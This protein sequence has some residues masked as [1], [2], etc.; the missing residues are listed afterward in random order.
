MRVYDLALSTPWAITEEMRDV[1]MK[2]AAREDLNPEAVAKELGRP[3]ENTR[4]VTVRDGVAIIPVSGPMFRYANLFMQIS[5][6]VSVDIL[7]T[8]IGAAL[9]DPTIHSIIL[10]IDSPGGT[11]KGIAELSDMVYAARPEKTIIAYV[12]GDGASGAYWFASA[13]S[14]VVVDSIAVL[15]SIGVVLGASASPDSPGR[16]E[17][18]SSQSP[19][20][21]INP[22]SPDGKAKIQGMIDSLAD[23]FVSRVA[24]NRNVTT[25]K[26]LSDFGQGWVFVGEEAVTAGLADRVG[27]LEGLVAELVM[28]HRA[29]TGA[30]AAR[31]NN[32]TSAPESTMENSTAAGAVAQTPAVNKEYLIAYHPALVSELRTEGATAERERILGIEA[33]GVRG[34]AELIA[35]MKKDP[36]VTPGAAALRILDAENKVGASKLDALAKDEDKVEK[37]GAGASGSGA[38]DGLSAEER[39]AKAIVNAK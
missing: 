7:A 33:I 25:E 36:A 37:P 6:G 4:S 32:I 35:S 16:I 23:V 28:K 27:S 30:H 5:G 34:H 15:G 18:V 11:A 14:E 38:D 13:A 39:E 29:T 20:K 22:G 31:G 17:F 21:R 19:Y 26:V 1:I 3:L 9:K 2:I 24:R 10:Y 12:H 8:D